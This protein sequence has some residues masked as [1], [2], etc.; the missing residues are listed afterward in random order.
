MPSSMVHL[1][2]AK[3]YLSNAPIEFYIGNLAPDAVST[4]EEKDITHFRDQKNRME[5]LEAFA[6]ENDASN[7]FIQGILFHLFL[8]YYWDMG[9]I[10]NFKENYKGEN[11]FVDYRNETA[12][13]SA[14]LY[15]HK[16]WSENLWNEMTSYQMP[17]ESTIC[18]I[19]KVDFNNYIYR[20][21]KWNREN[22]I[23]CSEIFSAEFVED[24]TEDV[25][26]KYR[27]WIA[28]FEKKRTL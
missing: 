24:F 7:L 3:K 9:P 1:L 5:A 18:G 11:W 25:V 16:S 27:V 10:R 20:N 6:R 22:N 19:N 13:L 4:R 14:W 2:T 17:F 21:A 23:A 28:Q 8:D 26:N 12:A 15:H